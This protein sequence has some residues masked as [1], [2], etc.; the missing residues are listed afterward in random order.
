[1]TKY[2]DQVFITIYKIVIKRESQNAIRDLQI[3]ECDLQNVICDSVRTCFHFGFAG[4]IQVCTGIIQVVEFLYDQ[5]ALSC[6]PQGGG[7]SR[8]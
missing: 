3:A 6:L 8:Y 5:R 4:F 7:L 1:M 2:L